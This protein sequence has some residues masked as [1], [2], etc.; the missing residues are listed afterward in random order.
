MVDAVRCAVAFQEELRERNGD[1]PGEG[2][3]QMDIPDKLGIP[4]YGFRLVIGRSRIDYDQDKEVNNRR[5]HGYS[6]ESAVDPL[7]R[8]IFPIGGPPPHAISDSF[9]KNGEVRHKH[10]SVDD[11]GKVV[12]M[13][14]TMRDD[15][16]VRVISFRRA[17][18][19]EREKFRNLTGYRL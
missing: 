13:I 3:Q 10:M 18:E 9:L 4:D 7:K 19:D 14:T 16:I 1:T 2:R 11:N 6:L 12:V 8:I 5:K 15:E 17:H